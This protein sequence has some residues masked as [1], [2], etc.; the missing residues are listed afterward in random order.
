MLR[1]HG[2]LLAHR[3]RGKEVEGRDTSNSLLSVCMHVCL[4]CLMFPVRSRCDVS[5]QTCLHEE[6]DGGRGK[7]G[8][9]RS[10]YLPALPVL[11]AWLF[12]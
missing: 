4:L 5:A 3:R 7:G 11:L 8:D 10:R 1:S 9:F 12:D 2:D 6:G